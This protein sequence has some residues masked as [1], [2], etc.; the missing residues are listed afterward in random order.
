MHKIRGTAIIIGEI[1]G[2]YRFQQNFSI[3]AGAWMVFE[4]STGGTFSW[5]T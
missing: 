2:R 4:N 3:D 5:Q 1:N